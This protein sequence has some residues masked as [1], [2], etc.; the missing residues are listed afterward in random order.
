MFAEVY[1][2]TVSLSSILDKDTALLVFL[3]TQAI[4]Y[5][6]KYL[7]KLTALMESFLIINSFFYKACM[8]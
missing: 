6:E 7:Y 3:Q 5:S 4:H 2:S 8:M 1:S